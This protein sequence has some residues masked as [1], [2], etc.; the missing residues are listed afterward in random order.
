MMGRQLASAFPLAFEKLAAMTRL[1]PLSI[2]LF[3]HFWRTG[4]VFALKGCIAAFASYCHEELQFRPQ[5]KKIKALQAIP[6]PMGIL[7][8][9]ALPADLDGMQPI[10]QHPLEHQKAG[11]SRNQPGACCGH[12]G[13]PW[14]VLH[15]W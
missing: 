7:L 8:D 4:L 5:Y 6:L 10:Q 13:R 9:L 2:A 11:S 3:C 14:L 12:R 15:P 1:A